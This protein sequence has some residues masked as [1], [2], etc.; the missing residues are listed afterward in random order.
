MSKILIAN[1]KANPAT[2]AEAS[3]L[4]KKTIAV[5]LQTSISVV[6]CPPF[7]FL[8]ELAPLFNDIGSSVSM[9]AQDVFWQSAGPHTGEITPDMLAN[10]GCRYVLI[11]HSDRRY[12]L[13]ETDEMINKKIKACLATHLTPIL[14]VGETEKNDAVRPDTLI[15]QLSRDLE[16]LSE[17]DIERV[18][19]AYEPIW[20]ISTTPGAIIDTPE[21]AAEAIATI[22]E[23]IK[24]L[25]PTLE[26][27]PKMFYGGSVNLNDVESFLSVPEISGAVVGGASLRSEEFGK[28]IEIASRIS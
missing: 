13:G 18:I 21:D 20:S 6:V 1:W 19:F 23:I 15:D 12:K 26:N 10:I 22:R 4:C 14:L 25:Y 17:G 3:E 24:K 11:G 7:V 2:F 5:A 28:M 9:G 16:G 27:M 8:E